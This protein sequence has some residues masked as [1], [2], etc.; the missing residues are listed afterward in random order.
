MDLKRIKLTR[1]NTHFCAQIDC[2]A[3]EC[4]LYMNIYLYAHGQMVVFAICQRGSAPHIIILSA[5]VVRT[6][7]Q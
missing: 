2:T 4:N 1:K 3:S 6:T 7:A 5:D